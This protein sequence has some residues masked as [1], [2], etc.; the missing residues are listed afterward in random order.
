MRK[1]FFLLFL[2]LPLL[3]FCQEIEISHG[4]YLQKMGENEVTIIW[5][6]NKDA[7]SWVELA[8]KGDDSFYAYERPRYYDTAFG[9]KRVGRL[10]RVTI[11]GLDPGTEYRYRIFSKEVLSYQGHRVLY[12]NVA[13]SDVY[14]QA[15]FAFRTLDRKKTQ[16]RFKVVNDIHGKNENLLKMLEGTGRSNTDLVIFNGD[17]VSMLNDPEEIFT[18]FMDTSVNIFAK[19]VPIFLARGNHETRGKGGVDLYNYF[20]TTSGQFY[21]C[22]QDGPVFFLV[23]DG[24]EDKPD[25][26][27]E[28]S[29]LAHFDDYRTR[30]AEWLKKV[31]ASE[32][33][34]QAP[35]R[36]VIMHIPPTA[37]TWH[38]TRDVMEKLIP[39]LNGSDIDVMLCGH[40]H[41]Y[42]FIGKGEEPGINFPILIND[43]ETWLDVEVDSEIRITQ[44]EMSGNPLKQHH[45]KRLR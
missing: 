35:F 19:E 13:A 44:K 42:R 1:I 24:G 6:T 43:D 8:P 34:R 11:N 37:S 32:E 15:P 26:D 31:V 23:L 3:L 40:T 16:L 7:L 25:S 38:G 22:F 17:M 29:E 28:Y 41:N 33:F 45:F 39:V 2:S 12:G 5:T 10:H 9:S 20:P 27:I 14:R 36:V 30:Q 18:R 21:Y 4:P